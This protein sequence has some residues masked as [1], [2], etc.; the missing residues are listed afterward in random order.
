MN[1]RAATGSQYLFIRA[2]AVIRKLLPLKM[3]FFS[4]FIFNYRWNSTAFFHRILQ[5]QKGE[6]KDMAK[7]GTGVKCTVTLLKVPIGTGMTG[8]LISCFF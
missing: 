1:L 7:I 5:A 8:K 4:H 2:T 6:G 3:K